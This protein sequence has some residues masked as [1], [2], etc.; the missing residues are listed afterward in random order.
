MTLELADRKVLVLESRESWARGEIR[1][2]GKFQREPRHKARSQTLGAFVL[3]VS[4]KTSLLL[5]RS[6]LLK[7]RNAKGASTPNLLEEALGHVPCVAT[8]KCLWSGSQ[9]PH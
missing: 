7:D 3:I 4:L 1:G 6:R 9:F 8:L 5:L 2:D